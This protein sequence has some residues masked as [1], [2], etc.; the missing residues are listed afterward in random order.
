[1]TLDCATDGEGRRAN[2]HGGAFIAVLLALVVLSILGLSL[3][4]VTQ[5]EVQ[6]AVNELGAQRT[7]YGSDSGVHLA[8]A[9]VLTVSSSVDNATV[10]AV[11]PMSFVLPEVRHVVQPGGSGPLATMTVPFAQRVEVTPFVP[12]RGTYCDMCPAAY[13]E[14]QLMNVN[15]AVVATA[16]R[17]G[18][19]EADGTPVEDAISEAHKQLFLMIGLQ[20]WWPPHWESIADEEQVAK[21]TQQTQGVVRE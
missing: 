12:I 20:P 18:W 17:V 4:L 11:T 10:T 9:R 8:I 7:F 3:A 6:I 14:V 2:E 1:M 15:H 16:D 5:S 13:G 19:T 21:V